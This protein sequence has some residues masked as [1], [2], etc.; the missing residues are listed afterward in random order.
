ML[1]ALKEH[2]KGAKDAFRIDARMGVEILVFRRDE[3][4]LDEGRDGRARKIK[5]PLAGIFGD[6]RSVARMDPRHHRRFVILERRIIRQAAF[7]FPNQKPRRA[8]PDDKHDRAGRE[9]ETEETGYVPHATWPFEFRKFFPDEINNTAD[10]KAIP[11]LDGGRSSIRPRELKP[12]NGMGSMRIPEGSPGPPGGCR[13]LES[14]RA[15]CCPTPASPSYPC[16]A[17]VLKI[18]RMKRRRTTRIMK[19]SG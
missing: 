2:E 7:E 10:L 18:C 5:T 6:K 3:S 12:N 14:R 15:T 16:G 4:V 9:N 1:V 8:S 19:R 17:F 13:G 11:A